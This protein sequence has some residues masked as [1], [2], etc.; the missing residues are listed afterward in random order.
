MSSGVIHPTAIVHP[1][2][3]LE[4]GQKVWAWSQLREHAELGAGASIGQGCYVGPGV[5]IGGQCRVQ[6]GALIYEPSVLEDS[7]FVGPG[8]VFTNDRFP[9]AV[10]VG[11]APKGAGDWDP[12]GVYV[13]YGAAI[14]ARAV[15]VGPLRIGKWAMVAAGAV[16]TTDVKPFALVA[17]VPAVQIGWV[18]RAGHRLVQSGEHYMCPETS[19]LYADVGGSL[20]LEA[21][22]LEQ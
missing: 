12:V 6:N 2:V 22:P 4:A 14:G 17:G 19:E 8:A 3:I 15:L 11:G 10:T 1:S 9:R 7:V 5:R 21:R 18:G 20:V 13:E 16:V